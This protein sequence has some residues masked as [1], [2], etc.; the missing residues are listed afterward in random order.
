MIFT[1]LIQESMFILMFIL[2]VC[3]CLDRETWEL[4]IVIYD[5][6]YI[7]FIICYSFNSWFS[8]DVIC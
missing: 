4:V 3:M 2:H 7:K 1:P 6:L 8:L 5:I